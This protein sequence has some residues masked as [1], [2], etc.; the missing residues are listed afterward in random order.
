MSCREHG[1]RVPKGFIDFSAPSNPLGVPE[2]LREAIEEAVREGLYERYP[3]YDYVELREAIASFYGVEVGGLVPLNGAAEALSLLTLCVR[4]RELVVA[5]PTF[6]EHRCLAA[7]AGVNYVPVPY[8][9]VGSSFKFPLDE[10]VNVAKSRS[11][12]V[13]LL[14]NPNNPTGA[15]VGLKELKELLTTLPNSLVVVDEAFAELSASCRG[16]LELAKDY[17]NLVVLRSFTKSFGV[18]GLRVGFLYTS[19]SRLAA[20]L[21]TCRQP[22]NVNS[23]ASYSIAKVLRERREDVREYLGRSVEV[24]EV[25]RA[26]LA[27]GLADLGVK[28]YE[29]HAP[30]LLAKH[31]RVSAGESRRRLWSRGIA[32]RDAS[33][34]PYLTEYHVR[35]SVRPREDTELLLKAYRELGIG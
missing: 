34:F 27:R 8:R 7:T 10:I 21:N 23:L 25:E 2:F 22:W 6:G 16:F 17:E 33:S 20:A 15:C 4:P 19:N 28:V 9:E 14:S 29:S 3:D 11:G 13:V 30:F 35:I 26:V 12:S 24:V 5:E 31:A 18:R 32:I 1:G